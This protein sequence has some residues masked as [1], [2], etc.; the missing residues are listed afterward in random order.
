MSLTGRTMKRASFGLFRNLDRFGIHLLPKHFYTPIQDQAWLNKNLALWARP[1]DMTSLQWDLN[2]QLRWVSEVCSNYYGEVCGFA[3]FTEGTQSGYGRGYGPV[4]AQVL[5]CVIRYFKPKR[6][7]EVGSGVSTFCTLKALDLNEREGS[8][9]SQMTCI[10]PF[11]KPQLLS[12]RGVTVVKKLLQEVDVSIFQELQ[13]G[14]LLF[15]DSSHAVKTGSDV[16]VLLLEVLPQLRPGVLVHIHDIFLP[17]TYSRDSLRNYFGWQETALL[18]ALLKGNSNF[19]VLSCLSALHYEKR[20][21]LRI[22]LSDY[23]PQAE[24]APGLALASSPGH[25][26][27]STWLVR[28]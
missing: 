11:P 18:L 26:P 23:S 10:E 16:P 15:I 20:E 12:M 6:V 5:H 14:D 3:T 9:P 8:D 24:F 13:S 22:V 1:T 17:Y 4:E 27:S 28:T 2:K 19:E 21:A 7:I 25:F